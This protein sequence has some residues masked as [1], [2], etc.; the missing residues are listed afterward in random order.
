M[1]C[2]S[3][4]EVSP[5]PT[6]ERFVVGALVLLL[7]KLLGEVC[8]AQLSAAFSSSIAQGGGDWGVYRTRPSEE[9]KMTTS[10][11]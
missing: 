7:A 10:Q 2:V 8:P 11:L 3:L 5:H 4:Q 6:H 1:D 9:M